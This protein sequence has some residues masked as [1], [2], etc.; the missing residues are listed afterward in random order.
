MIT[1]I[2]RPPNGGERVQCYQTV[3]DVT[4]VTQ[5]TLMRNKCLRANIE[6]ASEN[7]PTRLQSPNH[8]P[9]FSA[10]SLSF[11]RHAV[12]SLIDITE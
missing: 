1:L 8:P 10:N 3:R 4:I 11:Y 6:S 9:C 12:E 2:D 5:D 7:G